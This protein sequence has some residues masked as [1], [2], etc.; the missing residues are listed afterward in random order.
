MSSS[1]RDSSGE[2]T[3]KLGFSVVAATSVTHPFS[4][5]GRRASCWVRVNRC[6]SSMNRTVGTPDIR[7]VSIAARTSLTPAVTALSS[8]NRRPAAPLTSEAIVVLP[9]PG[10]PHRMI[11][12]APDPS[13]SRRSGEPGATR[14]P[15][16]TS[17]ASSRGRIRTAS[18]AAAST[19]RSLSPGVSNS[20]GPEGV[21]REGPGTRP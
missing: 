10:G 4:T 1:D 11:E 2:T 19:D 18:G 16:P 14:S 13:M 20:D 5:P 12:L 9:V 8:T 17:S 6:T 15:C 7:A 3:E 21:V